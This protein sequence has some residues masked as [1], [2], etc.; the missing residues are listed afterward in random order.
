MGSLPCKQKH[1][2]ARPHHEFD[3]TPDIERQY[4]NYRYFANSLLQ[5]SRKFFSAIADVN[6]ICLAC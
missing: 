1:P 2:G 6:L 5:I 3:D 4:S